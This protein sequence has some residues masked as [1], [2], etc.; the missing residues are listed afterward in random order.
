M[1]KANRNHTTHFFF[2]STFIDILFDMHDK[3]QKYIAKK[4]ISTLPKGCVPRGYLP[5]GT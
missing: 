2:D 5:K 1:V 3:L 4:L